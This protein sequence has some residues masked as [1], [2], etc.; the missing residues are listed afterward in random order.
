VN[1]AHC[2]RTALVTEREDLQCY[3]KPNPCLTQE[4]YTDSGF[5]F[6]TLF[7]TLC[8]VGEDAVQAVLAAAEGEE[9]AGSVE[10]QTVAVQRRAEVW[11]EGESSDTSCPVRDAS[12][13]T[14]PFQARAPTYTTMRRERE[15][16]RERA[17]R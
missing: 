12:P 6:N 14:N 11:V 16:E 17:K 10:Q 3:V 4:Y 5:E 13:T 7:N 1:Y 8:T 9:E 15:R 2:G